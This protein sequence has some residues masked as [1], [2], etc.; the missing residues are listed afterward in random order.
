M[1]QEE[2]YIRLLPAVS[3]YHSV[4]DDTFWAIP[5]SI[6]FEI[7]IKQSEFYKDSEDYYVAPVKIEN[8]QCYLSLK[9]VDYRRVFGLIKRKVIIKECDAC[10]QVFPNYEDYDSEVTFNFV[11]TNFHASNCIHI[12]AYGDDTSDNFQYRLSQIKHCLEQSF[13]RAMLIATVSSDYLGAPVFE[14]IK[15]LTDKQKRYM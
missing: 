5:F 14:N 7:K 3:D 10:L 9:P 13:N 1:E 2:K 6:L 12:K 8:Q 11:N 4:Y 15:E